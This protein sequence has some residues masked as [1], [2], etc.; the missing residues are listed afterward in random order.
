MKDFEK[1][2]E[3]LEDIAGLVGYNVITFDGYGYDGDSILD[4]RSFIKTL[5]LCDFSDG[6][7]FVED[8]EYFMQKL[9]KFLAKYHI[10]S[11]SDGKN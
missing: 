1:M 7:M 4:F 5:I 8:K 6:E 10:E 9:K 11:E 2:L 3:I